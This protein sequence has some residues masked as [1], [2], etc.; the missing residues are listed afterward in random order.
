MVSRST[1]GRAVVLDRAVVDLLAGV[2]AD[3]ARLGGLGAQGEVGLGGGE[4]D[5]VEVVHPLAVVLSRRRRPRPSWRRGV[6]VVEAQVPQRH[7]GPTGSS[8]MRSR[9]A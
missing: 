7:E 3:R 1:L 4:H 2:V 8:A 6:H 5:A 9:V